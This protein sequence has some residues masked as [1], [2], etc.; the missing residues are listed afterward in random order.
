M[1]VKGLADFGQGELARGAVQQPHAEF[2]FER[3]DAPAQ[4]GSLHIE[5]F[6]S[7]G[8]TAGLDHLG[9]KDQIVQIMYRRHGGFLGLYFSIFAKNLFYFKPLILVCCWTMLCSS[10]RISPFNFFRSTS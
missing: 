1:A 5:R 10:Y 3:A 6:G 4:F 2:L 9:E 7:G 8:I